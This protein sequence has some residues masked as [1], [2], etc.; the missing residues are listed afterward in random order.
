MP[1]VGRPSW[2]NALQVEKMLRITAE[3]P[4]T[5]RDPISTSG[6]SISLFTEPGD[7]FG[8]INP[9]L[10]T[11]RRPPVDR[12]LVARAARR[13]WIQACLPDGYHPQCL[14]FSCMLSPELRGRVGLPGALGRRDRPGRQRR[15]GHAQA[16]CVQARQSL[17]GSERVAEFR[18]EEG[19][20]KINDRERG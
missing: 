20:S 1:N 6:P 2:P 12:S 18:A 10:P 4:K 3:F 8:Q 7:S 14:S 19:A 9:L 15:A 13:Q 11:R 16:H 5:E 17:T